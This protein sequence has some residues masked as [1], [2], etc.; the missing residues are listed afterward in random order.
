MAGSAMPTTVAS[1][2]AMPEPSTVAVTTQRPCALEMRR[3]EGLAAAGA[4][5]CAMNASS[6]GK[7]EPGRRGKPRP[8]R[9]IKEQKYSDR[10]TGLLRT[11]HGP[12][13]QCPFRRAALRDAR[14]LDAQAQR[15]HVQAQAALA[16]A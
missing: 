11:D 16:G 1:S 4:A 10:T 13:T 2:A 6:R 14:P 15:A 8:V 12:W 5:G 3:P 7:L 9:F